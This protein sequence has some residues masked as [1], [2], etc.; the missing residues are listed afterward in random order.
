MPNDRETIAP[1]PFCGSEVSDEQT[2]VGDRAGLAIFCAECKTMGPRKGDNDFG[3]AREAWNR[4]AALTAQPAP[5]A[6]Q[7]VKAE[8]STSDQGRVRELAND[9]K[10]LLNR[11]AETVEKLGQDVDREGP[12]WADVDEAFE[13]VRSVKQSISAQAEPAL[14]ALRFYADEAN[15]ISGLFEHSQSDEIVPHGIPVTREPEGAVVADCGDTARKAL[16]VLDRAFIAAASGQGRGLGRTAWLDPDDHRVTDALRAYHSGEDRK[17]REPYR[18][19]QG[20]N[21]ERFRM[22]LAIETALKQPTQPAQAGAG[23][24]G[25]RNSEAMALIIIATFPITDPKN[26]DAVNM[27]SVAMQ[28]LGWSEVAA[29]QPPT[30]PSLREGVK[31]E[32]QEDPLYTRAVDIALNHSRE[33]ISATGL[34]IELWVD[35]AL[36]ETMLERMEREGLVGPADRRGYRTVVA[37]V[38]GAEGQ[39]GN[40]GGGR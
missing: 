16:A 38:R 39:D 31:P 12:L 17:W 13:V 40:A 8:A 15:Y 22:A 11:L 6:G 19:K 34:R 28:A 33:R 26:Q 20:E 14:E 29:S 24:V 21:D 23:V 2:Y 7:P 4:R 36:A 32:T 30:D 25:Q 5:V 18:T 35:L 37:V 9:T 3:P 10:E 27:Q 1:C